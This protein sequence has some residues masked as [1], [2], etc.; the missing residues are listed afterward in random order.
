M[1]IPTPKTFHHP[2]RVLAEIY[3]KDTYSQTELAKKIG[4]QRRKINEIV[5]GKRSITPEFALSLADAIGTTPDMWV[6][7]Q[8]EY[9]LWQAK[10][11]RNLKAS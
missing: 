11:K 1:S 5:N 7:M 2:G 9:D 6:H 3:M 8:A 10:Q 4:C